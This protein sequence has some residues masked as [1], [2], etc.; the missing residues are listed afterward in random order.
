MLN[1]IKNLDV[2]KVLLNGMSIVEDIKETKALARTLAK[3]KTSLP[4]KLRFQLSVVKN[5]WDY[6]YKVS[7]GKITELTE[8][9]GETTIG[10]KTIVLIVSD[11]TLLA[12]GPTPAG[13]CLKINPTKE[14][15]AIYVNTAW[16]QT[17]RDTKSAIL[18]HELAHIML[19][20]CKDVLDG[21]I[22]NISRLLGRKSATQKEI[23]ADTVAIKCGQGQSLLLMLFELKEKGFPTKELN[24]RIDAMNNLGKYLQ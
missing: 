19:G 11:A 20:H 24:T 15:Y 5:A 9:I 8:I 4:P 22:N 13:A 21:Y 16:V 12:M 1:F 14:W 6:G 10:N 18:A 7:T 23:D 17:D 2:E 3:I